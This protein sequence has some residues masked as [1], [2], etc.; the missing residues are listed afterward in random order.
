MARL[1][2]FAPARRAAC[3]AAV[4]VALAVAGSP[5]VAGASARSDYERLLA[6]V[7]AMRLDGPRP[8]PRPQMQRVVAEAEQIARR[9]G[10]SGYADNALWQA[11]TVALASYRVYR[12]PVDR[13]QGLEILATLLKRY[14]SS[15]LVAD[16][17]ALLRKHAP[18]PA[19]QRNTG[20]LAAAARPTPP[21]PAAAVAA[22]AAAASP[23]VLSPIGVPPVVASAA[24]PTPPP[25]GNSSPFTSVPPAIWRQGT[26]QPAGS[27]CQVCPGC[28][29][30][31][32]AGSPSTA[33]TGTTTLAIPAATAAST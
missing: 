8:T 18:S 11:A 10:G 13:T 23:V 26:W 4:A 25:A 7:E 17:R 27:T 20:T 9:H 33:P 12:R 32:R 28:S 30:S 24:G 3:A 21:P 22:S 15:S 1:I 14:P 2:F 5:D 6:R 16:A 19:A 29:I 31:P